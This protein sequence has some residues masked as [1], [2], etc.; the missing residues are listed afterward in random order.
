[1]SLRSAT[2]LAR[3]SA[4]ARFRGRRR[5]LGVVSIAVSVA[6]LLVVAIIGSFAM[7]RRASETQRAVA[8]NAVYQLA[9]SGVAA[10]ES[11]ERKYRLQPGPAP[12]A[13]HDSAEQQVRQ[14]LA[15]VRVLGSAPD[16]ALVTVV[17]AEHDQHVRAAARLFAAVD[18]HDS[19]ATIN[20]ID[21]RDVD[22]A[23]GVMQTEI[24]AAAAGHQTDSLDATADMRNT[25]RLVVAFDVAA[26]IAG[27][28]LMTVAGLA[29]S[30]SQRKLGT[31]G[32][33]NRHQALHD[34]LTG[35]PNRTLFQDRA[36]HAL[37]AA[38]RTGEQIAVML[39][40]LNRFKDVNDTLGHQYGDLLLRQVA[41]RFS[42][43]VR[44]SDSVARL[45]GDEFAVLLRGTSPEDAVATARRLTEVLRESFTV[46]DIS[47]DVDASIGIALTG[48]DTDVETALRHADIAMYEA[49][50]RH[51]SHAVYELTR[52]DHTVA[53]LALLGDLRRAISGGELF[54]HYQPKISASTGELH[55]VEALVRWRHPTRGLLPPA[56]FIPL[57]E[58]TAVIHP[59]TAEILRQALQQAR[60]WLDQGW[61]IPVA[62]NISARSLVDHTFAAQVGSLLH[63][64]GVPAS[65]LSLEL[66]EGAIMVDP[67]N[68]L[69]VLQSLHVMGVGLSIDDFGTGYSSM[70]Y[71]KDLPVQELKI[72]RSFVMGMAT[73]DSDAV[74]V[75]SAIDLGHNLGLHVVAEGV[76]DA[77]TQQALT[78]MGCDLLQGY[79][80]RR[81]VTAADLGPWIQTHLPSDL[82]P[83][84]DAQSTP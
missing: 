50:S 23:F 52:D 12:L 72:D 40:D 32:E 56:E 11:L 29:L 3:R 38:R 68:A 10:E 83:A 61:R 24:A 43:R 42:A 75:R 4:G 27:L 67:R 76:E 36:E 55:S 73:A 58:S 49:K 45:G 51:Q 6:G 82:Q 9:A 25:G 57:A 48:P 37:Q 33:L 31:Q 2:S 13:A 63:S 81:P 16:R 84:I 14:A 80:V 15:Q 28:V 34:S 30:R 69:A 62:V 19:T 26:L 70:A 77:A 35:L 8:L 74:L 5:G 59:L 22:P 1:M 46:K 39:I 54:L 7:D 44:A 20:G 79:H 41:D 64:M 53:R 78:A 17:S 21:T 47:L 60:A 71:L 65:L 18:A 66:T